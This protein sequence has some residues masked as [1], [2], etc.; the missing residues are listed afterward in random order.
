MSARFLGR[1]ARHPAIVLVP[2]ALAAAGHPAVRVSVHVD[3]RSAGFF[4]RA[5]SSLSIV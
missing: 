1:V 3:E 4:A 5:R 2:L